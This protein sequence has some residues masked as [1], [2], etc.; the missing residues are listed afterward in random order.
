VREPSSVA[1]S[2]SCAPLVALH[3][4]AGYERARGRA[5]AAGDVLSDLSLTLSPGEFVVVVGPNG[6]GKS[7]LLRVLSGTLSPRAGQVTLFG[8]DLA[9]LERRTVARRIA[10]VPQ[11]GEVAFGFSVEQ[12]VMMGRTPH[13]SGLQLA[14]TVD[15]TVV[16]EAM[17]MTGIL[18]LR[19]RAVAELSGGEQKL[20]ALARA[21]AQ[22]PGV[23][24]L[25]EPSA[26]LDPRHAVA[27][28]ELLVSQARE[29]GLSCLAI[30]HDLNLAAAFADRVVLLHR[31][32]VRA[33]GTVAEVMTQENLSHAFGLD[34]EM[35]QVGSVRFFVPRRWGKRADTRPSPDGDL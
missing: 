16:T 32:A 27:L 6:A 14:S 5:T 13:Q 15:S 17:A 24:L 23:L 21:L 18:D 22:K 8:Q 34:L 20:V 11:G 4:F 12:V 26:H 19:H 9:R 10:V 3:V 29:Q 31:G 25:D 33:C 7:T 1:P 2:E 35:G 28:F 30:A